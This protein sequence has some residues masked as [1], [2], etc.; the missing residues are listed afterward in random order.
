MTTTIFGFKL[1]KS[2]EESSYTTSNY[3]AG[4]V[5]PVA[6][7]NAHAARAW[8]DEQAAARASATAVMAE[9]NDDEDLLVAPSWPKRCKCGLAYNADAYAELVF[10][11]YQDR[12]PFRLDMRNCTCGSTLAQPSPE[13]EPE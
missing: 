3:G 12:G 1:I 7:R 6:V 11:G 13:P 2:T 9:L 5:P 8:A 4:E 10:V